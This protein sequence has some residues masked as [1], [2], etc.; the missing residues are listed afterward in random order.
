M[1][2]AVISQGGP[3]RAR[4]VKIAF[5]SLGHVVHVVNDYTAARA[6]TPDMIVAIDPKE[7]LRHLLQ[8]DAVGYRIIVWRE[9][10]Q[11][12]LTAEVVHLLA[13]R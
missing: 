10:Q 9:F 13:Q 6:K 7:E 3:R 12:A 4:Q 8:T 1:K 11:Q 2:I 5:E